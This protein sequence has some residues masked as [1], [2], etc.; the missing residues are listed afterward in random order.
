MK[1]RFLDHI[2]LRVRNIETAREFYAQLL[3]AIGFTRPGDTGPE[4][5]NWY[6]PGEGK[7][8]FFGVTADPDHRPNGTR[9]S[10]WADSREEV[11]RAAEVVRRAGGKVLEGPELCVEYTPDY[12]AFFFEDPD[13]NKLE[14]C[15]RTKP[16]Q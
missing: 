2:D 10:F 13:G 7:T 4:W 9:I 11:D 15:C 6:V 14:I 3:P 5:Y 12:Y 1:T 16:E 8:E